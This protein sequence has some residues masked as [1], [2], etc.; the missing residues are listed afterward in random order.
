MQHATPPLHLKSDQIGF[1]VQKDAQCSGKNAKSVSQFFLF[2][3]CS[4]QV[5][6][7]FSMKKI[8]EKLNFDPISSKLGFSYVSEDFKIMEK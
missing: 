5:Y 4:F 3:Q 6:G 7:T 8:D 2:S 1:L